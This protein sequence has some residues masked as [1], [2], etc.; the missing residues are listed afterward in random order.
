[1]GIP[2]PGAIR[3]RVC[4]PGVLCRIE[5]PLES[6]SY[7]H[8]AAPRQTSASC[9]EIKGGEY[10]GGMVL[11][12][13]FETC[14]LI[15]AWLPPVE[16]VALDI[17]DDAEGGGV[18]GGDFGSTCGT[19]GG[20]VY[21]VEGIGGCLRGRHGLEGFVVDEVIAAMEGVRG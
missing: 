20:V 12:F 18:C 4:N 16:G 8:P 11:F 21:E 17:V 15:D 2:R 7:V 10:S 3:I 6:I 1:M 13:L 14:V 9:H 5:G 19:E